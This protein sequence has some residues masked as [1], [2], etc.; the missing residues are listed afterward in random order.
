MFFPSETASFRSST[1]SVTNGFSP[2]PCSGSG[3]GSPPCPVGSPVNLFQNRVLEFEMK[4]NLLLQELGVQQISHSNTAAC[5]FVFV[6]GSDSTESGADLLLAA[7]TLV[8][9]FE[10]F[11]PGHDDVGAITD[12]KAA[13]Q[14]EPQPRPQ[15]FDLLKHGPGID[16]DAVSHDADF[17]RARIPKE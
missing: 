12:E 13:F 11:V 14:I 15:L 1:V 6:T 2:S 3:R 16:Y 8:G 9:Y 5:H 4:T 10:C 17:L 7:S